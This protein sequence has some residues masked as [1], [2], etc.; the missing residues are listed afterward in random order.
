MPADAEKIALALAESRK[1]RHLCRATIER[2]ATWPAQRNDSQAQAVKAAKRKLH[3][4]YAAYLSGWNPRGAEKILQSL[5]PEPID[6]QLREACRR[7]MSQHTSTAERLGVLDG[8]YRSVFEITG[9]PKRIL[10]LG[11][12][13]GPLALPWMHLPA[14]IEY[15]AWDIDHRMVDLLNHFFRIAAPRSLAQCKDVLTETPAGQV[16]VAFCMKLLPCLEQQ[17]PD[18]ARQLL[19]RVPAEF[20]VISF[21]VRSIGGRRKNMPANYASRIEP[22]LAEMGLRAERLACPAELVYVARRPLS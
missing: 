8:L 14:D 16:D 3:Q 20:I 5:Q 6:E 1:Y 4:V 17:Q 2:V 9:Q 21:P 7:I 12:G 22:V 11:C 18:I 10:D 19:S 15:E 13:L